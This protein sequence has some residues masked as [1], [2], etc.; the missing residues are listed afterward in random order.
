MKRYAMPMLFAAC[1][2]A[3]STQAAA[4]A[5]EADA[6]Q[7]ETEALYQQA[8]L[9][10]AEGRRTDASR[11]LRQ[12]IDLEPR[13]AGAWLDLAMTQ[14]GLGNGQEAERLFDTVETRFNPSPEM[15][16]L[17]AEMRE[18]G[19]KPWKPSSSMVIS[20]GRGTD[21]N[22]NQGASTSTLRVE[23]STTELPLRDQF[24]PKHD[25]YTIGGLD[26]LRDLTPN[27]TVGFAQ[28]QWRHN[29]KLHDYDSSALFAGVESPYRFGNWG[30]RATAIAGLVSLGGQIYQRQAQAQARVAP[31]LSLPRNTSVDV[32]GGIT[33]ND[34][35]S[36]THFD[37]RTFEL[38]PE[39]VYRS[40]SLFGSASLGFLDDLGEADRPGGDRHGQFLNLLARRTLGWRLT[41]ELAYTRQTWRSARAYAP[42]LFLPQIR[43]QA[44]QVARASLTYQIDTHHSL[45]LEARAVRNRENISIFQ[46]NNRQLQ[47]SWRWQ[48]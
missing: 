11:M 2:L 45:Q 1:A 48:P 15:L 20:L 7:A 28:L 47:L 26:Y 12:V 35:R 6:A 4:D 27:G 24:L 37:S 9:A 25:S 42:E 16:E 10:L 38:R 36:L 44:T 41:G 23:G 46:Y 22:V 29:D 18:E 5:P 31:P 19:C 30:M 17:I 3:A 33:Y 34:Y 43:D 32:M 8:L 14:C 39:F 40:A 13:H 21:Q